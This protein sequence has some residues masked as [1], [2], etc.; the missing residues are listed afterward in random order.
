[1]L[2]IKSRIEDDARKV[3]QLEP[4]DPV[5]RSICERAADVLLNRKNGRMK[6][7]L[8]RLAEAERRIAY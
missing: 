3:A 4:N 1:M 6:K 2:N 8:R 5:R 7:K